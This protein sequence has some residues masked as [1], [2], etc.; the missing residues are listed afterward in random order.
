MIQGIKGTQFNMGIDQ[1]VYYL[2]LYHDRSLVTSGIGVG[3]DDKEIHKNY[4]CDYFCG[5][6]CFHECS[7]TTE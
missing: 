7:G 5:K 6:Y 1:F 2:Q 4:I 3:F